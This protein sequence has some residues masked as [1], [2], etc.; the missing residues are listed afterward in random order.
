M[1]KQRISES[2]EQK[3]SPCQVE[4]CAPYK[5]NNAAVRRW[6]CE[7]CVKSLNPEDPIVCNPCRI[8]LLQEVRAQRLKAHSEP[9]ENSGVTEEDEFGDQDYSP[10]TDL[11]IVSDEDEGEEENCA[12]SADLDAIPENEK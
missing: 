1:K 3:A 10:D 4:S 9:K 5:R 8:A 11:E 2:S 7:R 6:Y 12:S